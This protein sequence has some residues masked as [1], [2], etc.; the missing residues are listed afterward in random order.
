[1]AKAVNQTGSRA[2]FGPGDYGRLVQ[3]DGTERWWVR[4]ANG[5]WTVLSHQRVVE[6]EDGT[7]TLLY[8]D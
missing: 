6:N 1:M 5:T 4:S 8:L 2:T 3:P 7:L